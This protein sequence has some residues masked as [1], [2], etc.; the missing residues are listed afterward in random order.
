MPLHGR[1]GTLSSL[2]PLRKVPALLAPPLQGVCSV[3]QLRAGHLG[4]LHT[5]LA[6][7]NAWVLCVPLT[8]CR[9]WAGRAG[10][11][12]PPPG[13]NLSLPRETVG[14]AVLLAEG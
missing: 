12:A 6:P 7:Q 11:A 10:G 2:L 9:C 3:M 1:E 5:R 4:A 14:A 8:C 13:V